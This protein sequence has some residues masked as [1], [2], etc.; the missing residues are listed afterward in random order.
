MLLLLDILFDDAQRNAPRG[1]HKIRM[2]PQARQFLLQ[3]RK[4]QAQQPRGTSLDELDQAMNT[5]LRIDTD[6][7]VD[8]IRHDF[9][10]FNL[11]LIFLAHLPDDLFQTRLNRLNQHFAPIFG[12][13]DHMVV[14]TVEHVSVALIRFAHRRQYTAMSYLLSR[15]DVSEA[16]FPQHSCPKQGLAC[17]PVAEARDFTLDWVIYAPPSPYYKRCK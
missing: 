9:Q 3:H 1:S 11:C 17:I 12:T 14:A 13:P 6:E 2:C 7:Q 10:L 8:M 4:F 5:E 16:G 15:A